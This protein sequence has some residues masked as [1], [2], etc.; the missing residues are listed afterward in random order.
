[1]EAGSAPADTTPKTRHLKAP[2]SAA[3]ANLDVLSLWDVR[4]S[5]V[6]I[7]V[8]EWV[9]LVLEE[10]VD[11]HKLDQAEREKYFAEHPT[12]VDSPARLLRVHWRPP[13]STVGQL[14]L[15]AKHLGAIVGALWVDDFWQEMSDLSRQLKGVL[16]DVAHRRVGSCFVTIE[17]DVTDQCACACHGTDVRPACDVEGGC[18]PGHTTY[19]TCGG[20]LIRE[21]GAD[22]VRCVQCKAEW[23]TPDGLARLWLML[24]GA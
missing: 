7:V 17:T 1:V 6:M 15:L 9:R 12:T 14:D 22:P 18:G 23:V 13:S 21:N 10:N 20:A 11:L 24:K 5:E 19:R 16:R 2:A 8:S 3:P 4:S